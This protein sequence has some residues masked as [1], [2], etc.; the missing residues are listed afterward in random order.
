[1][2]FW[3]SVGIGSVVAIVAQCKVCFLRR[4]GNRTFPNTVKEVGVGIGSISNAT[5]HLA[6][7]LEDC[8]Q[9]NV[10][11]AFVDIDS[12]L[13]R[14][15][16]QKD[17]FVAGICPWIWIDLFVAVRPFLGL[18][19]RYR[20]A[21]KTVFSLEGFGG[22]SVLLRRVFR[23]LVLYYWAK[24]IELHDT[25]PWIFSNLTG[26]AAFLCKALK[27]RGIPTVHWL[28]GT[29]ECTGKFWGYADICVAPTAADA[30]LIAGYKTYGQIV[31]KSTKGFARSLRP[32]DPNAPLVL[33]TNLLHPAQVL[34]REMLMESLRRLFG[35]ARET[36]SGKI[37]WRP[38]PRERDSVEF[39]KAFAI[40]FAHDIQMDTSPNLQ[41]AIDTCGVAVCS[42]S[43]VIGDVA[44]RGIMPILW[45]ATRYEAC[46]VWACQPEEIQ[47]VD[48]NGMRRVLNLLESGMADH[49]FP[50]FYA[51]WQTAAGDVPPGYFSELCRAYGSKPIDRSAASLT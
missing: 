42:F 47:C 51:L 26:D 43:G 46:G 1:M 10:C 8:A 21:W 39:D 27:E 15:A 17:R 13:S 48:A 9:S 38:H 44:R 22:I 30:D 29:A 49:L 4:H 5:R 24:R 32:I 41:T 14:S 3:I 6:K 40:A 28:H 16:R 34:P 7:Y 50:D 33:F 45:A 2:A 37:L 36:W 20:I 18:V 31:V 12:G 23:G 19:W 11:F 25:G 35:A